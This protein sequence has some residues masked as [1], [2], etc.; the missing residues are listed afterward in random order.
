MESSAPYRFFEERN[1]TKFTVPEMASIGALL[2]DAAK[3]GLDREA[4]RRKA[5]LFKWLDEHWEA[6][7]PFAQRI[8]LEF[9]D[10]A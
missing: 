4:K 6:C 10:T 1:W 8:R 5:G 9:P 2:G 7:L 3:I